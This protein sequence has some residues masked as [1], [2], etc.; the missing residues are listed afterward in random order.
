MKKIIILMIL[1]ISSLSYAATYNVTFQ[2]DRNNEPDLAGYKL[3][4][5]EISGN[6]ADSCATIPDPNASIYTLQ[7]DTENRLFFVITAYDT[8][9]NESDYSNEVIFDIDSNAPAPP[10]LFQIKNI[11]IIIN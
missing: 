4:K 6:Y 10:G 5:S 2:W 7:T 1:L 3:Y 8:A 11:S 9:M